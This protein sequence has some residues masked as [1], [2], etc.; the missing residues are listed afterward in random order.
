LVLPISFNV[1]FFL[2]GKRF[3]YPDILRKPVE[4]VLR[5][6]QEGGS[7]LKLIWLGLMLTAVFFAP[8]VV[9][10]NVILAPGASAVLAV[11]ISAGQYSTHDN[12]RGCG[13]ARP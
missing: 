13:C 11:A 5:T 1:F 3:E 7:T 9:L 2:L 4:H 12:T 6:F 8:T 10:L